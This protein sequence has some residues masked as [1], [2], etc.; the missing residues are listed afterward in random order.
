MSG[1]GWGMCLNGQGKPHGPLAGMPSICAGET[2]RKGS[3]S[4]PA[5]RVLTDNRRRRTEDRGRRAGR[6]SRV[7]GE[8]CFV[9]ACKGGGGW[10]DSTRF[11]ALGAVAR[12]V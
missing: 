9:A 1:R 5:T 6:A 3:L 11:W 2:S 10:V 12:L 8:K 4:G 7:I